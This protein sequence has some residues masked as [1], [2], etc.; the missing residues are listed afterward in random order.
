VLR[1][2]IQLFA[3]S[4]MIAPSLEPRA[5]ALRS[6]PRGGRRRPPEVMAVLHAPQLPR[7]WTAP[8]G[9]HLL[10]ADPVVY[11]HSPSWRRPCTSW[12]ASG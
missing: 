4:L 11:P 10:L 9:K 6:R 3:V 2:V 5:G 12:P 8:T 1:A 7:V